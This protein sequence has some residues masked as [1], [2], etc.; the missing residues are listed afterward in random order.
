MKYTHKIHVTYINS[1]NP[2]SHDHV[3]SHHYQCHLDTLKMSL[4]QIS[5]VNRRGPPLLLSVCVCVCVDT[6]PLLS[7]CM[8]VYV[9]TLMYVP[10][11]LR[12]L[13]WVPLS[14]STLSFETVSQ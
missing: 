11:Q 3:I 8:F 9:Y 12:D 2:E 6:E 10:T 4:V 7:V 5:M 13:C 1:K 14:L